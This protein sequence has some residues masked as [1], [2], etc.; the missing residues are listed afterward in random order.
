MTR[1][2]WCISFSHTPTGPT[3]QQTDPQRFCPKKN[4]WIL[5]D[6]S[7]FQSNKLRNSV[8][9]WLFRPTLRKTRENGIGSCSGDHSIDFLVKKCA[10][11]ESPW[12]DVWNPQT[13]NMPESLLRRKYTNELGIDEAFSTYV[14]ISYIIYLSPSI[15]NHLKLWNVHEY[16]MNPSISQLY[17]YFSCASS[18]LIF[19]WISPYEKLTWILHHGEMRAH[20]TCFMHI[21]HLYPWKYMILS[22]YPYFECWNH[23][24]YPSFDHGTPVAFLARSTVNSPSLAES[25]HRSTI[26]PWPE[27]RGSRPCQDS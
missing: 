5:S 22:F 11:F 20:V 9:T 21:L 27:A 10:A 1:N 12:G 23:V 18:I 2:C 17:P 8:V 7:E 19:A 6:R 4:K 3:D 24:K 25:C 13:Q 26:S 15:F 14:L 16:P